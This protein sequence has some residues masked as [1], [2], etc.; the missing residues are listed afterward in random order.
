MNLTKN[1]KYDIGK[2]KLLFSVKMSFLSMIR[3]QN[4]VIKTLW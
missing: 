3:Q 2:I 1:F 4:A